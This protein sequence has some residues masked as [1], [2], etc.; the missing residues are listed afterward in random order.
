MFVFIC[1]KRTRERE[2]E[3]HESAISTLFLRLMEERKKIGSFGKTLEIQLNNNYFATLA[4]KK[5]L[6]KMKSW[7]GNGGGSYF[8]SA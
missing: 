8:T 7:K 4:G 2:R 5:N 3:K 6:K 1:K